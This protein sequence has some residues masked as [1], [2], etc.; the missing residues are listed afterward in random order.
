MVVIVTG[1]V[2][3]II[4]G[5]VVAVAVRGA[6]VAVVVKGAVVVVVVK[7]AAVVVCFCIRRTEADFTNPMS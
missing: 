4:K 1:A 5:V 3:G 6:V 7:G 2:V